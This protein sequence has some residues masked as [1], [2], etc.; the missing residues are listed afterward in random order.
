M[1]ID[2]KL[3]AFI[4]IVIAFTVL[5]RA[6]LIPWFTATSYPYYKPVLGPIN[7]SQY[8]VDRGKARIIIAG[9]LNREFGVKPGEVALT[10]IN[11]TLPRIAIDDPLVFVEYTTLNGEYK[12]FA[13]IEAKTGI[14]IAFVT[15]NIYKRLQLSAKCMD[16]TRQQALDIVARFL[17]EK[18]DRARPHV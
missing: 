10:R 11:Y 5:A 15:F 3:A 8:P 12:G 17:G 2:K 6:G 18:G 9:Y 13:L 7:P 16:I 4:I 1:N 14:M